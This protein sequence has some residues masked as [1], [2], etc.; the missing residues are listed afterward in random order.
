MIAACTETK[1]AQQRRWQKETVREPN[2]R[3]V[4]YL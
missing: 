4:S 2:S 3:T 1:P